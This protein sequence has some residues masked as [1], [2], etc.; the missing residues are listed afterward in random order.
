MASAMG[1]G[2]LRHSNL[3]LYLLLLT[4]YKNNFG[5]LNCEYVRRFWFFILIFW[6]IILSCPEDK[7]PVCNIFL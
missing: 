6:N 7:L 2:K 1:N 5:T 3:R 4:Y